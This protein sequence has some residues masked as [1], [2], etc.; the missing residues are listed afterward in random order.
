MYNA[1]EIFTNILK[2]ISSEYKADIY[3]LAVII[4]P[5]KEGYTKFFVLNDNEYLEVKRDG[6]LSKVFTLR[7]LL[8]LSNYLIAKPFDIPIRMNGILDK[9]SKKYEIPLVDVQVIV[10]KEWLELK[11][12]KEEEV[13]GVLALYDAKNNEK[14]IDFI[15]QDDITILLTKK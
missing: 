8:G 6:K 13:D 2:K 9:L 12:W 4:K 1:N 3:D 15:S 14:E 10:R 7:D 11:E 5:S